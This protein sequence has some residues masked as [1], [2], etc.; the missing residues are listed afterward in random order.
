[1]FD[2]RSAARVFVLIGGI[3][4]IEPLS[5]LQSKCHCLLGLDQIGRQD[6]KR[7]A[8]I[9]L[10]RD[11]SRSFVVRSFIFEDRDNGAD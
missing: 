4:I 2:T 9:P 11:H 7:R 6:V 10:I 3:S 5:I 8:L 1:M